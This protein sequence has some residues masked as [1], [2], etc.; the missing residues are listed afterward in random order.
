MKDLTFLLNNFS[1]ALIYQT[2]AVSLR[3]TRMQH[4]FNF[5]SGSP[6]EF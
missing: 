5:S 1:D 4:G 6:Y 3:Y 2:N